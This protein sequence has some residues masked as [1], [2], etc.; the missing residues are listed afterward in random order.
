MFGIYLKRVVP[1]VLP[2]IGII[3]VDL[4]FFGLAAGFCGMNSALLDFAVLREKEI[5][6]INILWTL[7]S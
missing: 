6:H 1:W 4:K 3:S 7:T 5:G 2:A